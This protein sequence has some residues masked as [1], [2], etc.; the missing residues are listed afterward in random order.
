M[1]QGH[2]WMILGIAV[3]LTAPTLPNEWEVYT[4]L[5]LGML[6]AISGSVMNYREQRAPR[7]PQEEPTK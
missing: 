1:N 3:M 7:A 5:G 6:L 2:K 4:H